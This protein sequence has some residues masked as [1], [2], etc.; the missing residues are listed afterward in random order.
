MNI[1]RPWMT[2][3]LETFRDNVRRFIAEEVTPNEERWAKQ[4]S[5]DRELWNKAGELGLL[6]PA[7]PEAYGGAGGDFRHDAIIL[8]EQS[9]AGNTAWAKGVH[10]IVVHYVLSCGTEEQKQRWLPRLANGDMVGAIAMTEPGTGSDL[11]SIRCTAHLDGQHYVVNGAKTFISNGLHCG[12]LIIVCKTST[13]RPGAQGISLLV[14]ETDDLPGFRRGRLLEKLGQKGQDTAELFFEDVAIPQDNLLGGQEGKGFAQLMKQ[15][16]HE[17]LILGV[18]A[19]AA[20]EQ[21]I[22]LTLDYVKERKAFGQHLIEF[23][24][25][26][27]T[28]AELHTQTCLG[29]SFIDRCIEQALAGELDTATASMAKLACTENQCRV[30]DACLQLFGGYGYMMEYPIAKMYA[31]ARVQKIYGGS[32]EI[33]KEIIARSLAN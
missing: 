9:Y 21:A 15:L 8:E 23:Q 1:H 18:G 4:Q 19:Q 11:Q 31:D 33:M 27:F 13:D 5:V 22:A 12:L 7:V 16:P 14:A 17:R 32:N 25:T 30:I 3:E 10:E 6:C 29:R 26:R 2:S 24:N 28:L 20:A